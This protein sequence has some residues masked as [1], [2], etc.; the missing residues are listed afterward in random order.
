MKLSLKIF[1][2]YLIFFLHDHWHIMSSPFDNIYIRINEKLYIKWRY[3]TEIFYK[4]YFY[5]ELR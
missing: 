1:K 5:K 3:F 2:S 4:S